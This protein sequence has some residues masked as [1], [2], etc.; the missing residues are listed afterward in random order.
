MQDNKLTSDNMSMAASRKSLS[1]RDELRNSHQIIQKKISANEE[2]YV[3]RLKMI[4][5]RCISR[6]S[7][8]NLTRQSHNLTN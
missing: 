7:R 4:E 6:T 3:Q 5:S 8:M 2:K 1:Y